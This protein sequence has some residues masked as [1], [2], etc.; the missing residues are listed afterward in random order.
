VSTS[1]DRDPARAFWETPETVD[2]FAA[3]D[4]DHRLVRLLPLYPDP[5]RVR[6]LDLGCAAGRNTALLAERGFDVHALDGSRAMIEAARR[7]AMPFLGAA[8]AER[9]IRVGRMDRLESFADGTV[10]LLIA[11]G[12]Y[13]N[14]SSREEW[15]RTLF[16]SA[17]VLARGGLALVAN[18]TRGFAPEGVTLRPVPGDPGLVDGLPSGR[19]MLLDA[20]DLDREMARHGF[21][22]HVPTETV[23]REEEGRGRRVTA[24]ALYR[25]E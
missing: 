18:H 20:P 3:R 25:R 17:R 21:V 12:I 5:P 4:P 15:D 8:E 9:R 22:P 10:D 23:I 1:A 2:M 24:N 13:H 14:A 11:L 19:S 6:V 16:E 7:R